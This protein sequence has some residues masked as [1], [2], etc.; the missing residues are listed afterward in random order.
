MSGNVFEFQVPNF[1]TWALLYSA[2]GAG[3]LWFKFA[4]VEQR[5]VY[6]FSGFLERLISDQD[7][8]RSVELIAFCAFG[9]FVAVSIVQPNSAASAISAGIGWTG[10]FSGRR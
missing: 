6:I 4:K 9:A 7:V 5:K 8:R 1:S 3:S 2:I 10:F